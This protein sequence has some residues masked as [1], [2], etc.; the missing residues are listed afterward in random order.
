MISA[1]I[2]ILVLTSRS[3]LSKEQKTGLQQLLARDIDWQL[4][5]NLSLHHRIL[6]LFYHHLKEVDFFSIPEHILEQFQ[7]MQRQNGIR[8][9]T[10]SACLLMI[11]STME[12]ENI[13]AIPFKGPTLTDTLFNDYTFRF[14]SDLDILIDPCD[15]YKAVTLLETIGFLP[16][17]TLTEKQFDLLSK[18]D[19]EIPLVNKD[20]TITIDL[21]WELTG[22]Y[23]SDKITLSSLFD[24]LIENNFTG[25]QVSAIGNV[26]YLLFL[27]IHGNQHLWEYLDH[28][29]CVAEFIKSRPA[30]NWD[31]LLKKAN[32][33]KA[34]R[35][36]FIGLLLAKWLEP[37]LT[38]TILDYA[39][40]KAVRLAERIKRDKLLCATATDSTIINRR[41]T[42]YHLHTLDNPFLALRYGLHLVFQPTREDWQAF[43]LPPVLS[44]LYY[45]TRPFRLFWNVLNSKNIGCWAQIVLV[46]LFVV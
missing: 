40:P 25:T 21:Q 9:L 15:I 46:S 31:A 33:L 13:K 35:I 37:D 18:T 6:P 45:A 24:G 42:S 26:D 7:A 19:N 11:L 16:S 4:L 17:K 12:K 32:R 5:Y 8:N 29:C 39:D 20:N 44:F 22:G 28:V 3:H 43:P 1:E 41:F 30:L 27:C 36:L 2:E 23:F 34:K 38:I 14:F 10:L